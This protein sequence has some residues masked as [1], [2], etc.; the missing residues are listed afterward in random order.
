MIGIYKFTNPKG[1]VY[2]G[3]SKHI[4][5]RKED[6]KSEKIYQQRKIYYSIKKYGLENHEFEII[7]ECSIDQ[8]DE[9]EI[10]WIK[11][12]NSVEE[13]LNL[14]YG[15]DGGRKSKESLELFRL[16]IMKPILQYDLEGNFIKEYRGASEAIE[17]IGYGQANNIN[18]CARGKYKSTYGFRWIYKEKDKEIIYNIGNLPPTSLENMKWTEERRIKTHNSRI[19]EKRGD[20]FK[21]K[22]RIIK[23]K[24]VYQYNMNNELT[25][26]FPSFGW[27]NGS[28]II[29]TKMLRKIINKNIYCKGYKYSYIKTENNE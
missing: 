2:I 13:G 11:Q 5:V 22:M 14:T 6:Y 24:T 25:G 10:Y 12:Y 21:N 26:E 3:K 20:D 7:E 9:R 27:F 29:G 23:T 17:D 8:L 19:G 15:G 4:E 1:K 18:D 16:N 28:G